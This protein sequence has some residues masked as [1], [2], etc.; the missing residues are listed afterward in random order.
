M[1]KFY[2]PKFNAEQ[3][4]CPRCKVYASQR[5]FVALTNNGQTITDTKASECAHCNRYSIW[6]NKL[7]LFPNETSAPVAHADMPKAIHEDY[8]EASAILKHSPRGAAALLRLAVQKLMVE[9]GE[10][11]KDINKDIGSLV[12]KGLPEEVQQAL[13]IVRVVGNESVHPGSF[14]IR[15]N[16]DTAIQLFE[17]INF[18]VEERI[19][20]KKKINALYTQLPPKKLEGIEQRDGTKTT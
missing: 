5:W 7:L 18:I 20:R 9:L 16:Q 1:S 15:D 8:Q 3:F 10:E 13:D 12:K 17:L 4:H 6:V 2:P 14:D 11:G 19:T